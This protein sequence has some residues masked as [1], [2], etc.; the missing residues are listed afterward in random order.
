M[1][2]TRIIA[3]VL[4]LGALSGSALAQATGTPPPPVG[5][6]QVQC[7]QGWTANSQWSKEQFTAACAKLKQGQGQ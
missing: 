1:I 2:M 6:T 4:A 3:S 7:N 5:P